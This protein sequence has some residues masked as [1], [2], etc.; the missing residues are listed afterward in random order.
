LRLPAGW[1]RVLGAVP[2]VL[3]LVVLAVIRVVIGAV[4]LAG[5]QSSRSRA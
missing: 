1:P 5:R 3:D 4:R 2:V